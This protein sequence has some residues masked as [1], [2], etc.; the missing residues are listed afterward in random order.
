[1]GANR[2]WNRYQ[3]L[4]RELKAIVGK[5]SIAADASVSGSVG[6]G[7]SCARTG[8][9]I[10]TITLEDK[11]PYLYSCQ[12]TLFAGTAVDLVP[13]VKSEDVAGAK[14]IVFELLAAATPTDPGAVCAVYVK[15][16]LKNL[17]FKK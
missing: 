4:D 17:S 14:T 2:N 15:L 7:Y 8:V 10:Y 13:Q 1:M 3:S 5:I 16:D 9:G 11:Y 12:L 6:L